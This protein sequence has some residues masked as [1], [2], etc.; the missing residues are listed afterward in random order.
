LFLTAIIAL[1]LLSFFHVLRFFGPTCNDI[2]DFTEERCKTHDK[3][4]SAQC[5]IRATLGGRNYA[6]NDNE[7]WRAFKGKQWQELLIAYSIRNH[8]IFR[9]HQ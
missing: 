1:I 2:F 5:E 3:P 9:A 8:I 7:I 4:N 6:H